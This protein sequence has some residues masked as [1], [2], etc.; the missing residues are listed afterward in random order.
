MS[1]CQHL[2]VRDQW[3]IIN[4]ITDCLDECI[5]N[6]KELRK[7]LPKRY[8]RLSEENFVFHASDYD[9]K[10]GYRFALILVFPFGVFEMTPN[11][12]NPWC[13]ERK[14]FTHGSGKFICYGALLTDKVSLKEALEISC[15]SSGVGGK[16]QVGKMKRRNATDNESKALSFSG[17]VI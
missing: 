3:D 5:K 12:C 15:V 6:G 8:K 10:Y 9:K 13:I 4:E 2:L 17:T 11:A 14:Y 7:E 16:I 1:F